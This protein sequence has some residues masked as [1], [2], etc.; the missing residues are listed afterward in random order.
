MR[1]P[2]ED[3]NNR[4]QK[5]IEDYEKV[6]TTEL[7]AGEGADIIEVLG[8]PYKKFID[9]NVLA[10]M[11]E[12]IKNDNTFDINKYHQGLLNACKYK[13]NLYI[14]PINFAF[15]SFGANKNIMDKEGLNIDS[16]K[17]TWKEFL[18]IAQKITKDKDG[19][20]KPDQYAL[21]KMSAR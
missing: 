4:A 10:N 14:M 9:K 18:S 15:G 2:S 16:T 3:E 19:D 8:L 5:A 1:W 6:I 11:S 13:D 7:M 17:W 12:I 20:G 21:P